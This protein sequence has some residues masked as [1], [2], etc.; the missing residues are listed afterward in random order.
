MAQFLDGLLL[1][2]SFDMT[3]RLI[4]FDVCHLLEV[5]QLL[6]FLVLDL[7]PLY[8]VMVFRCVP[9]PGFISNRHGLNFRENLSI[10]LFENINFYSSLFGLLLVFIQ[11]LLF[12]SDHLLIVILF[13]SISFLNSFFQLISILGV[14][15]PNRFL[16]FN[17]NTGAFRVYLTQL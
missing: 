4:S 6:H 8:L 15:V 16:H 2:K 5:A 12:L 14:F 1:Q 11:N 10:K 9:L 17:G 3:H 13:K 7:K